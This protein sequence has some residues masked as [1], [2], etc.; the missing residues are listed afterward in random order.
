MPAG[1]DYSQLR[2]VKPQWQLQEPV[3]D[4]VLGGRTLDFSQ[5]GGVLLAVLLSPF[6]VVV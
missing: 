5:K 1:V 6:R 2:E 4:L 3:D